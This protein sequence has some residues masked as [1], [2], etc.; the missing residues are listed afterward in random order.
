MPI[1][2]FSQKL[3]IFRYFEDYLMMKL[4]QVL[5]SFWVVYEG[6]SLHIIT[7]ILLTIPLKKN[8][9]K[10]QVLYLCTAIPY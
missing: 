7:Q 8:F 10:N 9:K 5:L 6:E 3:S 2:Y 1:S 4:T